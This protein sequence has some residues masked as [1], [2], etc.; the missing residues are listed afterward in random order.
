M[1]EFF[2]FILQIRR[3]VIRICLLVSVC[4]LLLACLLPSG[5]VN[6][7]MM[8]HAVRKTLDNC[9]PNQRRTWG[10]MPE[11]TI[12]RNIQNYPRAPALK[13]QNWQIIMFDFTLCICHHCLRPGNLFF[14]RGESCE[15]PTT[16]GK[17]SY[18]LVSIII[19]KLLLPLIPYPRK[20]LSRGRRGQCI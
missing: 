16:A 5:A 18:H 13:L 9:M 17:L 1:D 4:R 11:Q 12:R 2:M 10:Q 20:I 6:P 8:S 3:I 15:A 7:V 19:S 14:P